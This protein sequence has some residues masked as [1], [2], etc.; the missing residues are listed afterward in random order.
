MSSWYESYEP[1]TR[2]LEPDW[3]AYQA[4]VTAVAIDLKR[5]YGATA[6]I[7][8]QGGESLMEVTGEY[9]RMMDHGS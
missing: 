5:Y 2:D 4:Y 3:S 7:F 9:H 1:G 8:V 6:Q